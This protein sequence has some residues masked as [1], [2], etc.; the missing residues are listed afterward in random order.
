MYVILILAL[1]TQTSWGG[2]QSAFTSMRILYSIRLSIFSATL[3]AAFALVLALPTAF[4]LS[5]YSFPGRVLM[6]TILELPMVVS[7]AA[8]GAMLLIFFSTR[9]GQWI[10]DHLVQVVFALPGIVVAQFVTVAGVATRLVKAALDEIPVRYENVARTLGAGPWVAFRTVTLPLASRGI[11]AAFIL[12][13]AKSL[14]EFGAT[15]ML[16][17]TLPFKTETMPIAIYLALSTADVTY[18]AVL[19][20]ILISLGLLTLYSVRLLTKRIR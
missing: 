20:L 7:P 13:W 18:A 16:A 4:A 10:Q 2:L 19:I 11:F 9:G 5:R 6:D 3:A 8:L 14:G 12:S 17:G 1:L 15:I